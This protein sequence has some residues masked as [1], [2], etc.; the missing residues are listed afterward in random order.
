LLRRF[1][2]HFEFALLLQSLDIMS[3]PSFAFAFLG[4]GIRWTLN[5]RTAN[6]RVPF[7]L[8]ADTFG[9]PQ[10]IDNNG[11][12]TDGI[13]RC[14]NWPVPDELGGCVTR[15]F[16]WDLPMLPSVLEAI[17]PNT[18]WGF[19]GDLQGIE[20]DPHALP[21]IFIGGDLGTMGGEF[22]SFDPLFW[23]HHC[24]IDK[25]F[26]LYQNYAGYDKIKSVDARA[27]LHGPKQLNRPLLYSGDN[28]P[29]EVSP[30]QLPNKSFSMTI[31][32][33]SHMLEIPWQNT[34]KDSLM[35]IKKRQQFR[36]KP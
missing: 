9:S 11:R 19:N 32:S 4:F 12:V 16:R 7:V 25:W 18:R 6:Q 29:R 26:A 3:E 31:F 5:E 17:T 13:A 22:S 34:S 15:A 23:L 20:S 8:T 27:N 30:F 36:T 1:S 24:N 28:I 2:T 21:H 10:G 33:K 35:M 14:D